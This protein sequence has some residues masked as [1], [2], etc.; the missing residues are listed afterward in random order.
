MGQRGVFGLTPSQE[1]YLRGMCRGEK[2]GTYAL[3]SAWLWGFLGY[4]GV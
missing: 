1:R 3:I 4:D 2:I